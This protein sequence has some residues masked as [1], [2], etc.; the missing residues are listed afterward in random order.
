MTE[1]AAK[2]AGARPERSKACFQSEACPLIAVAHGVV[3]V[4]ISNWVGKQSH[5]SALRHAP[6]LPETSA[7]TSSAR[8]SITLA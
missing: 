8:T 4:L 5:R 2:F 6:R 1:A 7:S 3:I